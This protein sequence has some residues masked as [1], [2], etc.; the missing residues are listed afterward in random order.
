MISSEGGKRRNLTKGQQAMALAMTYPEPEKGGRGN[1]KQRVEETSAVFSAKRLAQARSVLRHSRDLAES[2]AK[3]SVSLD[4]A[5]AKVN[6]EKQQ[7]NS[8]EAKLAR[9][10]ASAPDL[11]ARVAAENLTL[12]EAAAILHQREIDLRRA[13]GREAAK[14]I[15]DFAATVISIHAAIVAGEDIRIPPDT[16]KTLNDALGI[17]MNDMRRKEQREKKTAIATG[18]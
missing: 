9:L 10:K 13:K 15:L 6:E 4:E 17:L 5:L 1:K 8:T 12:A 11:A 14:S 16:L 2:V 3:G 18:E 7:A